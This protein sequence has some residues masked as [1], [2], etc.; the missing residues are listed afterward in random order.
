MKC[1]NK[2]YYTEKRTSIYNKTKQKKAIVRDKIAVPFGVRKKNPR[3]KASHEES[4]I[5]LGLG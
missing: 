2:K 5:G 3:K 1:L 4:G